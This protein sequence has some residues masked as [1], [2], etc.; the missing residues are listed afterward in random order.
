MERGETRREKT[1]GRKR[2]MKE[3]NKGKEEGRWKEKERYE[4]E[5][6]VGGKNIM[7]IRKSLKKRREAETKNTLYLL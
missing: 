1:S 5:R 2:E 6:R 4:E 7:K 3:Q